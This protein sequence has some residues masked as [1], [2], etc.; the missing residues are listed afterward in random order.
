MVVE[1]EN[2]NIIGHIIEIP[3]LCYMIRSFLYILENNTDLVLP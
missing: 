2:G 3:E 1:E